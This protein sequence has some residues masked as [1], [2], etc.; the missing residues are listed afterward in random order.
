METERPYLN[1]EVRLSDLAS[2]L[3]VSERTVSQVLADAFG[4]SFYDVVNGYRVAEAKAR[5]L[6]PSFANRAVL[7]IGLDAGFSSKASFNRV[8]KKQTG[9][10]PSAYRSRA[11]DGPVP[12]VDLEVGGDGASRAPVEAVTARV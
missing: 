10:T 6:D 4:G 11:G 3:G 9:E 8:F 2:S 1:P 12:P 7:S 5:L